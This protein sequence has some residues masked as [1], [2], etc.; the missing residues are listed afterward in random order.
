MRVISV[1]SLI[2]FAVIFDHIEDMETKASLRKALLP[3]DYTRLDN[4]IKVISKAAVEIERI[5]DF[6]KEKEDVVVA[7]LLDDLSVDPLE[8]RRAV[9]IKSIQDR[10]N[11]KLINKS[12]A[13]Y[14]GNDGIF[15]IISVY[16]RYVGNDGNFWYALQGK[17]V[18]LFK[19]NPNSLLI[20]AMSDLN[21]YVQIPWNIF[22]TI[23]GD[24]NLVQKDNG[25]YYQISICDND[26]DFKLLM[27]RSGKFFSLRP[28]SIKSKS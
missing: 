2:D 20:L 15:Y 11:V 5:A 17:W 7:Q 24:L 25:F 10:L 6:Q 13:I 19:E 28:Y 9:I 1:Q 27:P 22:A 26:G 16:K 21:D 14:R 18:D 3:F 8:R 4:L 23:L 12:K